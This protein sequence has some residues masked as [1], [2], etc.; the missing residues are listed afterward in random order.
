MTITVQTLLNADINTV[1]SAIT[2]PDQMRAWY[3]EDMPDFKPEVGFT[4]GF[5]MKSTTQTFNAL[6]KVLE[7]EPK[8]RIVCEW[9]YKAYDGRGTVAFNLED[10]D[11]QTRFT[12]ENKGLETFPQSVPEFTEES[13]RAGWEYFVQGR[14]PEYLER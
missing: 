14:L 11:G 13:C 6:W 5:P 10:V 3:F 8:K 9:R 7:V 1:W 2:D 4:T 12:V